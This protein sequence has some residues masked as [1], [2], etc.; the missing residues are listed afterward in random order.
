METNDIKNIWKVGVEKDIN[1]YSEEELSEMIVRSATKSIK[2]IYPGT[3]F[4]LIVISIVCFLI[5]TLLLKEQS[6]EKIFVD[7]FA[8]IILS[9]AYFLWER[10]AYKMKKYNNGKPIKVWL[11]YRINEIEKGVKFNNKYN[12]VIYGCSFLSAM[13][14]YVLYQ[15]VSDSNPSVLTVISIPL[16]ILIYLLIVRRSLNKNYQKVLHELKDLCKQFEDINK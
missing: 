5:L 6:I 9:V 11:E 4:R 2:A 12:W 8:L 15:V 7:L 14:F 3:I 10:S 13:F 1:P 16:G